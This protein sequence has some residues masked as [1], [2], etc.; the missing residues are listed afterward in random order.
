MA[1]TAEQIDALSV[2]WWY[3]IEPLLL[4]L[5]SEQNSD[6]VRAQVSSSFA[7]PMGDLRLP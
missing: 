4:E 1:M 2:K 7:V 5:I 3:M 6:Y